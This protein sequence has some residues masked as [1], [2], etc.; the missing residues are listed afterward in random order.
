MHFIENINKY[1]KGI[2]VFLLTIVY[3]KVC[4]LVP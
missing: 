4:N 2:I 3:I 1:I